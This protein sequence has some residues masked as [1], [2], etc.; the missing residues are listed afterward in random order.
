[1]RLLLRLRQLKNPF[2]RP[3]EYLSLGVWILVLIL[4]ET[5][6][7]ASSSDAIDGVALMVLV[8]LT[9]ATSRIHARLGL[10]WVECLLNFAR[11]TFKAPNLRRALRSLASPVGVDFRGAPAL[12]RAT[13][14]VLWLVPTLACGLLAAGLLLGPSL[15]GGLHAVAR[16]TYVPYLLLLG[17]LWCVLCAGILVG[18][19]WCLTWIHARLSSEANL[20]GRLRV[21]TVV[22]LGVLLLTTFPAAWAVRATAVLVL[23]VG[24]LV[25]ASP[26]RFGLLWLHAGTRRAFPLQAALVGATTVLAALVLTPSLI[27]IGDEVLGATP[28]PRDLAITRILARAFAWGCT[29]MLIALLARVL[30]FARQSLRFGRALTARPRVHLDGPA[31]PRDRSAVRDL[32]WHLARGK[33]QPGDLVL[34]FRPGADPATSPEQRILGPTLPG[35]V[36]PGWLA[37]P[38]TPARLERRRVQD[39]RRRVLRGTRRALKSAAARTYERGQGYWVCPHLWFAPCLT[40]DQR[41]EP[42]P[43]ATSA[44]QAGDGLTWEAAMSWGARAYLYEVLRALEIDLI[45]LEDGVGHRRLAGVLRAMFEAHDTHGAQRLEERHV[46]LVQGVRVLIQDDAGL[47]APF[48]RKGLPEPNYDDIGRA[49][50]LLIF[51]DRGGDERPTLAPRDS[52]DL[53]IPVLLG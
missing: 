33:Q 36:P 48:K 9:A 49:R 51:K 34:R 35:H 26:V 28:G 32:G 46:S 47:D 23:S 15:P 19:S 18:S 14:A 4:L 5:A 43:G 41:E 8:G 42:L 6:G 12:P 7:S 40:R 50:L 16:V 11:A 45:F 2:R 37:Q 20:G 25:A 29:A 39:L 52:S 10:G 13:P 31:D 27:G 1:M 44:A 21:L 30:I 24:A 17:A 38:G 3:E 22:A 53:P